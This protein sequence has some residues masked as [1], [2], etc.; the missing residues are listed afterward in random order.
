MLLPLKLSP[1]SS[2]LLCQ[3]SESSIVAGRRWCRRPRL[4]STTSTTLVCLEYCDIYVRMLVAP[5]NP[6]DSP[7]STSSSTPSRVSTLSDSCS[8]RRRSDVGGGVTSRKKSYYFNSA[9]ASKNRIIAA[10]DLLCDRHGSVSTMRMVRSSVRLNHGSLSR[11][12]GAAL[13]L[14][15]RVHRFCITIQT[16]CCVLDELRYHP[17]DGAIERL[18]A[19]EERTVYVPRTPFLG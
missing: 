12:T 18:R 14:L 7:T 15:S 1:P 8:W 16:R 9:A 5:I 4:C 13:N 17:L 11:H 19:Q 6:S 3:N 10:V 2:G